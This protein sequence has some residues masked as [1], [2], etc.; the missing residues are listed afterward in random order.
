MIREYIKNTS[1]L[2]NVIIGPVIWGGHVSD[3]TPLLHFIHTP[4]APYASISQIPPTLFIYPCLGFPLALDPSRRR[5]MECATGDPRGKRPKGDKY[6]DI[7]ECI[8]ISHLV[9]VSLVFFFFFATGL[10]PFLTPNHIFRLG[11]RVILLLNIYFN[12][13]R[14]TLNFN[15]L[16]QNLL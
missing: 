11:G 16:S 10:E 5:W 3:Q 14:T 13:G 8:F 9:V 12:L 6:A 2:P 15:F 1:S 4:I 7:E